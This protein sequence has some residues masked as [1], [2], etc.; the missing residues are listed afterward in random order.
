MAAKDMLM[1]IMRYQHVRFA[2]S[3]IPH[4][5]AAQER[6]PKTYRRNSLLYRCT[7]FRST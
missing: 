3:R 6:C 4:V 2:A 7:F 5:L 1:H